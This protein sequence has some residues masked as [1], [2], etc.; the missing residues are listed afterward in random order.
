MEECQVADMM[1]EDAKLAEAVKKLGDN[2]WS[3]IAT[4]IPG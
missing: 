3:G 2:N 4:L 1:E